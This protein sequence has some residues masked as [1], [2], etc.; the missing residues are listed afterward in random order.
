MFAF[1]SKESDNFI[2]WNPAIK[3]TWEDFQGRAD[4]AILKK[5]N[6]LEDQLIIEGNKSTFIHTETEAYCA[7][8]VS[9]SASYKGDTIV[10]EV[11]NY[12]DKRKSWKK[13]NSEYILNHEQRHFDIAEVCARKFRKLLKDSVNSFDQASQ[14]AMFNRFSLE[15]K[16]EQELYDSITS[17]SMNIEA[18]TNYNIKIDS[19]LNAYKENAEIIV[20]KY[21][22]Q[23][24]RIIKRK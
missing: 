17:H 18:Q 20:K 12:F 23:P 3:L 1:T 16:Y 8:K 14:K 7:H 15:D 4:S 19:L 5:N 13:T 24:K 21:A 10:F 2:L 22:P 11:K 9:F 6:T